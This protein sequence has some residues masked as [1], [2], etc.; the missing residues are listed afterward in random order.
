MNNLSKLIASNTEDGIVDLKNVVR[1]LGVKISFC[2]TMKDLCE[3]KIQGSKDGEDDVHPVIILKKGLSQEESCTFIAI[4][5]AEYILT[6]ERVRDGGIR[7]DIFFLS[8]IH[9]QRYSYRLL[10]ATR[11]AMSE[12]VI[13]LFNQGSPACEKYKENLPYIPEFLRSCIPGH[14]ASFLLSNFADDKFPV[15]QMLK[16]IA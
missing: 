11:L 5:I 4:A 16:R 8:G 12:E 14:S 7:Y 1:T 10:L 15:M 3:I 9:Q 2:D 13:T 6:Y